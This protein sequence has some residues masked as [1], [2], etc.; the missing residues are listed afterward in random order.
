MI[1]VLVMWYQEV[2]GG[3]TWLWWGCCR[4]C[5]P[6]WGPE[7]CLPKAGS[8]E[9]CC[10]SVSA[11]RACVTVPDYQ[12]RHHFRELRDEKQTD[13]FSGK[14]LQICWWIAHRDDA[15]H[16]RDGTHLALCEDLFKPAGLRLGRR[17]AMAE[18]GSQVAA[19]SIVQACC[20]HGIVHLLYFP[21]LTLCCSLLWL[22]PDIGLQ[23]Q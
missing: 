9:G 16:I 22:L 11:G 14:Q 10:C 20:I 3:C 2:S 12:F 18:V 13:A 19:S 23:M 6:G 21:L 5:R 1:N 8:P 7:G 17:Q 15:H 4:C